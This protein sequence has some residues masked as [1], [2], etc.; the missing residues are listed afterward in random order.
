MGNKEPKHQS[1]EQSVNVAVLGE[2]ADNLQATL[3]T[4][5]ADDKET[6]STIFQKLDKIESRIYMGIGAIIAAEIVLKFLVK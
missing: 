4:H 3:N 1:M 2:K 6:F 5:I